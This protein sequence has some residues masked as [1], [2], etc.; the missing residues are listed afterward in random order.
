MEIGFP[1]SN[2]IAFSEFSLTDQPSV[3]NNLTGFSLNENSI[4]LNWSGNANSF[5]ILRGTEENNLLFIDSTDSKEYSDSNLNA[6]VDYYYALQGVDYSKPYPYS[7]RSSVI[8]IF[9]HSPAKLQSAESKSSKSVIVR[10]SERVNTTIENLESFEIKN[11]GFPNSISPND[12]FSY[13]LS[14]KNN[15][16]LGSNTLY[17]NN[18]KDDY[19]SP[20]ESDSTSFL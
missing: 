4:K 9:T 11:F 18:L 8:K 2:G 1:T 16:P 3:P 6:N 15:L 5:I 13:L 20:I 12:Q 7:S 14:F 10:F 17:V 19:G